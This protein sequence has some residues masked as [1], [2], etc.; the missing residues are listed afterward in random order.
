MNPLEAFHEL[1][2]LAA[3]E[4]RERDGGEPPRRRTRLTCMPV[5]FRSAQ[6]ST[7]IR[8]ARA[9]NRPDST[10]AAARR[11]ALTVSRERIRYSLGGVFETRSVWPGRSGIR[12]FDV[13]GIDRE[14]L[15]VEL[16]RD[17]DAGQTSQ[18]RCEVHRARDRP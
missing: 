14:C 8:L 7:R 18:R 12:T 5:H 6:H 17:R 3:E 16:V 9:E 1:E 11:S 13:S 15:A 10:H 4:R 2:V